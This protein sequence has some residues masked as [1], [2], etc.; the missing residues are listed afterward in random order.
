MRT[1]QAK[2][3]VDRPQLSAHDINVRTRAADAYGERQITVVTLGCVRIHSKPALW[4][5]CV[6]LAAGGID[7]T[8]LSA[9]NVIERTSAM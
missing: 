9:Y 2:G 8:R 6:R 1:S 5:A 3:D 7:P 4:W